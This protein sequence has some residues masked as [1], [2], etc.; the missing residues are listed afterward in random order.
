[1]KQKTIV[2]LI[3]V[4]LLLAVP[5]QLLCWGFLLPEC[6]DTSFLGELKYKVRLLEQTPGKRIVLVGGSSVA[7]GVD[8]GLL[9]D[10]FPEYRFLNFVMYA[11]IVTSVMLDL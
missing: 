4:L 5:V 6:Y 1:M 9:E 8:S 10:A 2:V 7:F 11:D 3:T